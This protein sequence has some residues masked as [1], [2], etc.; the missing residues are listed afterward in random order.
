ML[1]KGVYVRPL[2]LSK[3]RH[4]VRDALPWCMVCV[5]LS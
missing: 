2:P 1:R 5:G 4:T 3:A